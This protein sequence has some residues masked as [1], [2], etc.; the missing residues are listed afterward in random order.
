MTLLTARPLQQERDDE[1]EDEL[2]PDGQHG[3]EQG[4][5]DRVPEFG[6]GE[7]G[8]IVVEPDEA[9]QPAGSAGIAHRIVDRGDERDEDADA[10]Q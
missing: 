2:H 3:V 6:I 8:D 4:N 1:T 10:D 5:P 7:E 9:L